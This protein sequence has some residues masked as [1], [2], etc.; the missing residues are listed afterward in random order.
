MSQT[1]NNR[2]KVFEDKSTR[3]PRRKLK[4]IIEDGKRYIKKEDLLH[5]FFQENWNIED[6]NYHFGIGHRIVRGSLYKWFT[7]E[8]IEE[9]HRKKIA[10]KQRGSNNSNRVNWY[11]PRKLIPLLDLEEAIKKST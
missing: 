8:E 10:N 2:Q 5:Y 1:T 6:F 11:K 4:L 9:S 3:G 7:R